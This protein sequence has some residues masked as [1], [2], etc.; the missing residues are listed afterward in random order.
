MN[1]VIADYIYNSCPKLNKKLQLQKCVRNNK[2]YYRRIKNSKLTQLYKVL[3]E[4]NDDKKINSSTRK[5]INDILVDDH[6]NNFGL[7]LIDKRLFQIHHNIP[8]SVNGKNNISNIYCVTANEHEQLHII[9]GG[10]QIKSL[11]K[12]TRI[13]LNN[14]NK[15]HMQNLYS[16]IFAKLN[17]IENKN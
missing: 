7:Q 2:V 9:L 6:Q 5:F 15:L 14:E 11:P 13:R 3:L 8:K 17:E 10:K 1:Q 12:K 4:L 16:M